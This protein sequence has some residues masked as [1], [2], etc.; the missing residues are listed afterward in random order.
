MAAPHYRRSRIDRQTYKLPTIPYRMTL[1]QLRS[2]KEI[3]AAKTSAD[4]KRWLEIARI[5]TE[6]VLDA[7]RHGNIRC[8]HAAKL[9]LP[10]LPVPQVN[11]VVNSIAES[12]AETSALQSP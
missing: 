5:A 7:A 12:S 10:L 11:K 6:A 3:E 2:A 1:E 9:I 4:I 8:Q